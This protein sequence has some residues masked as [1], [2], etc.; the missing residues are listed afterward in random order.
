MQTGRMLCEDKGRDQGDTLQTK[1][2]QR[3]PANHQKLGEKY[4]TDSCSQISE[5]KKKKKTIGFR[6]LASRTI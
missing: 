2:L 1:E 3:L 5:R 4:G 6:L